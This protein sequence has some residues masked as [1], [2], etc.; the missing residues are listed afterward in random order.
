MRRVEKPW[1]YELI[2]AETDL[3][4]GKILHIKKG[5]RLSLQYH[6]KKDE[7]FYVSKGVLKLEMGNQKE[8]LTETHMRV[9]DSQRIEPGQ[10]HRVTAIETCDLFEVSSTELDDVVRLEDDYERD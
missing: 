9:G 4:V 6:N 8:P 5:E 7:T 2:F 10:V 1:G 3:Y